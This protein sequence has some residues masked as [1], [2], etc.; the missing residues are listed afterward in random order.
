M[1]IACFCRST[2][3]RLFAIISDNISFIDVGLL[4]VNDGFAKIK[5]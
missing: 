2:S 5:H 4:I 1:E 3:N